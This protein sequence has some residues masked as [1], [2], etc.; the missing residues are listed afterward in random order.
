METASGPARDR[1]GADDQ[2]AADVPVARAE[3]R[4]W[5]APWMAAVFPPR[6]SPL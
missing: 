5:T 2:P 4:T 1:A 3:P 6:L